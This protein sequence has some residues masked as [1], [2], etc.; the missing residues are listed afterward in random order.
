MFSFQEFDYD[1][2]F[3][4]VIMLYALNYTMFL[5]VSVKRLRFF[6]LDL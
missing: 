1:A 2:V 5:G 6:L 4:Y 3:N